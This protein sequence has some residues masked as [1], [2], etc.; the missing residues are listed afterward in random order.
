M[1]T[2]NYTMEIEYR[3]ERSSTS[4]DGRASLSNDFY[5]FARGKPREEVQSPIVKHN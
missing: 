1:F 2:D 5:P 3:T 4:E